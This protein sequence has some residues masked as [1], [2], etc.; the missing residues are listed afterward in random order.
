M[1]PMEIW[2]QHLLARLRSERGNSEL[3]WLLVLIL[4]IWL[5]VAYRRIVVQ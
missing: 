3:V 4:I 2:L 1:I 5:L